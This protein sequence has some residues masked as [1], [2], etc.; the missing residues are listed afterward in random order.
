RKEL[1]PVDHSTVTYAPFRKNFFVESAEMRMMAEVEV[2]KVR[3]SLELRVHGKKCPRPI[4][5]WTQAGLA[6]NIL[7]S[8]ERHGYT[9]PFP[10]QCQALPALM[11]GRDVIGI[12]KTGSGKTVAYALP[13]LRHA[14]DQPPLAGADSVLLL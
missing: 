2:A 8:L 6:N 3:E 5:R 7:K 9:A 13:M 14:L 4:S 1:E 10:I 11:A 12:A